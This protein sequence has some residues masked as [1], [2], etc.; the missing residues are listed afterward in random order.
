MG[1]EKLRAIVLSVS[2]YMLKVE[3]T[4]SS[5]PPP[6]FPPPPSS[7]F[8][9]SMTPFSLSSPLTNSSETNSSGHMLLKIGIVKKLH[10]PEA[11]ENCAG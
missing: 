7:F 2:L 6:P 10:S 8:W 1:N 5:F 3:F 9:N 11:S 4:A